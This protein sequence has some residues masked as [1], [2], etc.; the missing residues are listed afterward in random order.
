[1][2]QMK[3]QRLNTYLFNVDILM[4][5]ETNSKAFERLLHMLNESGAVDFKVQS[6]FQMGEKINQLLQLPQ[7]KAEK[8]KAQSPSKTKPVQMSASE[9]AAKRIKSYIADN[10]LIRLHINKGLGVKLSIPCRIINYDE[11]TSLLN[12]YHVDEKQVYSF[13]IN[14]I[15][16]FIE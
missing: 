14:E 9:M 6:G 12:V 5:G 11:T 15:D 7:N 10:R 13:S 8:Q 3:E 1:M 16:D 4:E 2:G